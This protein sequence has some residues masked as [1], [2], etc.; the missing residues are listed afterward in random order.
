MVAP[1]VAGN[2]DLQVASEQAAA[3]I[4]NSAV[5]SATTDSAA[6][7]EMLIKATIA[8]EEG[9]MKTAAQENTAVAAARARQLEVQNMNAASRSQTANANKAY[10]LKKAD[11]DYAATAARKRADYESTT[12]A[13]NEVIGELKPAE[14]RAAEMRN[15]ANLQ[16]YQTEIIANPNQFGLNF[17]AATVKLV[18]DVANGTRQ[19]SDLTDAEKE[20]YNRA[21]Q[22]I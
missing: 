17:D 9:K 15:Q 10:A 2:Y 12:N 20:I 3:N 19:A 18:Q 4:R 6:N 7:R 11:D 22:Q 5:N 14:Q 8:G 1:V 21:K 13:L 16:N